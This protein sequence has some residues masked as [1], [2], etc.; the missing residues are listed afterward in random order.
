MTKT[1]LPTSRILEILAKETSELAEIAQLLDQLIPTVIQLLPNGT[2]PE[3]R[4]LQRVDAL[5]QHL[6]DTARAL[7][8]MASLVQPDSE[9]PVDALIEDVRLKYFR[10]LLM[11]LPTAPARAPDQGQAQL[12]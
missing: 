1:S 10:N 7:N 12:F 6:Q 3:M 5:H 9:M 8:T 2:D 11:D 4:D